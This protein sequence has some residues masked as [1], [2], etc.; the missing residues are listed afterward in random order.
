MD[1]IFF[2]VGTILGSFFG[3]IIDRLPR[4]ES[5]IFGRS[6]CENCH[7]PLTWLELFPIFSQLFYRSRCKYCGSKIPLWYGGLEFLS[8]L[9]LLLTWLN[10]LSFGQACFVLMS[11]VLSIFDLKYHEFPFIVWLIFTGIIFVFGKFTLPAIIF[12]SLLFLQRFINL[13]IGSGDILWLLTASFILSPSQVLVLI[14][15]ASL[16]GISQIIY[17]KRRGEIA[18]IPHLSLGYLVLLAVP[19]ILIQ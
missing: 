5:I 13:R 17:Q 16:T 10:I 9:V 6:H 19:Q 1:I 8:G 18:F 4:E 12:L 2:I 3:L 7:H 11:L 14:E 15:I